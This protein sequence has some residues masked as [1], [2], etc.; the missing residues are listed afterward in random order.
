VSEGCGAPFNSLRLPSLPPCQE[1]APAFRP[2]DASKGGGEEPFNRRAPPH[3]RLVR[4]GRATSQVRADCE[5]V[6]GSAHVAVVDVQKPQKSASESLKPSDGQRGMHAAG[7]VWG[8]RYFI[9]YAQVRGR[10]PV[11]LRALAPVPLAAQSPAPRFGGPNALV[12]KSLQL[13][14]SARAPHLPG[15]SIAPEVGKRHR[16]ASSRRCQRSEPRTTPGG[17]PATL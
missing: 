4:A 7:A 2:P 17:R 9:A 3:G 16:R 5:A 8:T 14:H 13:A 10:P 1:A 15:G 11:A 6:R 12:A